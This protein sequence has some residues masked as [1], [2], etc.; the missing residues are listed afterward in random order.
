MP[1][2]RFAPGRTPRAWS[3]DGPG[4]PGSGVRGGQAYAGWKVMYVVDD[5]DGAL[6]RV[7]AA[8]GRSG[9][10]TSEPYGRTAD[11][12]DDQGVEF[13]L[14]EAPRPSAG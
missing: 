4:L 11:C 13:W 6:D 10:V 5:L 14:W 2:W 9:A 12:A 3:A 1:G 8:G 7:L